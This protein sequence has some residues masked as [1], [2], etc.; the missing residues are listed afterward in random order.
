MRR[1][2]R[3]F[4]AEARSEAECYSLLLP[5]GTLVGNECLVSIAKSKKPLPYSIW[6]GH[7]IDLNH[8]LF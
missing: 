8:R 6:I 1:K 5:P 4:L 2:E 7:L 3:D